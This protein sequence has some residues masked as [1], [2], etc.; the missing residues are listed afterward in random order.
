MQTL[1]GS[2][3]FSTVSLD[4]ITKNDDTLHNIDKTLRKRI[5]HKTTTTAHGLNHRFLQTN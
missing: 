5:D 1:F 4:V 3:T 2:S